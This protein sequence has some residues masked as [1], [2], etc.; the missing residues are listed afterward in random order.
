MQRPGPDGIAL[1]PVAQ[2]CP[3]AVRLVSPAVGVRRAGAAGLAE[4]GS[5]DG[6]GKD[7]AGER[8]DEHAV[9]SVTIA[10]TASVVRIRIAPLLRQ[11]LMRMSPPVN[12]CGSRRQCMISRSHS[13]ARFTISPTPL[14]C[15]APQPGFNG[16]CVPTGTA[17]GVESAEEQ[18]ASTCRPVG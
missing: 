6:S 2:A 18:F 16:I 3:P 13:P 8:N 17:M 1:V 4:L 7:G 12:P 5:V 10:A 9:S 11:R 15:C 14:L